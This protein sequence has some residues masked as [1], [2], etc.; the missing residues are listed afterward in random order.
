MYHWDGSCNKAGINHF[1]KS[2]RPALTNK[3]YQVY[4]WNKILIFEFIILS[5]YFIDCMLDSNQTLHL[6]Y[7]QGQ[8]AISRQKN[9]E[10]HLL[11]ICLSVNSGVLLEVWRSVWWYLSLC[12]TPRRGRWRSMD[13]DILPPLSPAS[14]ADVDYC[15]ERT[16]TSACVSAYNPERNHCLKD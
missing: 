2:H 11:L 7:L 13:W 15:C 12:L 10:K 6:Q 16:D 9:I 1:L 5:V 14:I 4:T 3:I 8:I